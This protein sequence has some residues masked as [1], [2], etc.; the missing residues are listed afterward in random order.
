[1]TLTFDPDAAASSESGMY[2]LPF[3]PDNAHVVVIPVPFE[4][5]T[6]YGGGT[7]K[8]PKAVL[9]A[10][11]QVD[12]FDFETGRPYERGIAML[13]I[14]K[15]IRE[16]NKEASKLAE[17]VVEARGAGDGS[18]ELMSALDRVN[19]ISDLVNDWVYRQTS[20][21]LEAGKMPVVLGGDHSVP[22][23]AIRAYSEKYPGLGILHLDAH[24]ETSLL[25]GLQR[26]DPDQLAG[27][28]FAAIVAN[29]HHH[30]IFPMVA[31]A[32]IADAAFDAQRRM[33]AR[34]RRRA[35]GRV[36]A[37]M[38]LARRAHRRAL[39][40]AFLAVRA[41]AQCARRTWA[42]AAAHEVRPVSER[43]PLASL[44]A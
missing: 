18:P 25:I 24:A 13:D 35:T 9:R 43:W 7:S 4:A 38:V 29:A 8:G 27:D 17:A 37:D 5:T 30:R 33:A 14:P 28:L 1:M 20:V 36:E 12:L 19:E 40:D 42:R 34:R 15:E 22:F 23:G 26:A 41:L 44:L 3:T 6:S 2:G 16:W 21:L 31:I 11:R 32:G 39:E 10:S